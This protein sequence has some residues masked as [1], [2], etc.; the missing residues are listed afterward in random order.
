MPAATSQRA[1]PTVLLLLM[2]VVF[3]VYLLCYR[4]NIQSGDS[5]RALDALTSQARYG[6]WLLDESNWFKAPLI[7]R[8]AQALPLSEY[9]VEERLMLQL[10]RPL[11]LL[12]Q[13]LPRLGTIHSVW[14]FNII[15]CTLLTGLLYLMACEWGA[16]SGVAALVAVSA[17]LSS[18]FFA[19]S[20]TF[21]REPLA[22]FFVLLALYALQR[23]Q[24]G[25]A[26][27]R[28]ASIITATLVLFCAYHSKHSTLLALPALAVAALPARWF[29][30][31][32]C[33]FA[34]CVMGAS[35]AFLMLLDPFPSV[36][37][38]LLQRLGLPGGAT[39][40]IALRSYLL[41]PGTSLWATS[42]L[43][44]LALPGA[45]LW[46]RAGRW[47]ILLVLSLLG[48]SYSVGHAL[49]THVHWFGGLSWPP[50]FL[51]PALPALLL[52]AIPLAARCLQAGAKPLPALWCILLLYG[53]WIQFNS[54]ALSWE[55]YGSE[56]PAAAQGLGEWQPAQWQSRYFRWALLPSRWADLGFD[57]LWAR[58]K[59][60][61]WGLSFFALA[62]GAGISLLQVLRHSRSRLRFTAPVLALL[63]PVLL[64]G[65][66]MLAY[67]RDPRTQSHDRALQDA[68]A[69]LQQ[70]AT[71]DDVLLMAGNDN[72][73]FWLQHQ[74]SHQPR[75]IIL[76]RPF[77]QAASDKQPAQLVSQNP[78]DWFDVASFRSI[79]HLAAGH[80]RLWLLERTNAFMGWS[81]RPLERY[82]SLHYYPLRET[83]IGDG[84]APVRLL[85]FHTRQP[86][87]NPLSLYG[88]D[89]AAPFQFGESIALVSMTVP[90]GER[91]QP[92]DILAFSLLWQARA[93]PQHDATVASFLVP[94]GKGQASAQ[95]RDS[96]PQN[97]FSPTSAWSAGELT[98]DNR[99]MRIPDDAAPGSYR[100]WILLYY[101]DAG[102]IQRL[103]VSGREL[104]EAGTA[105]VLPPFF[106]VE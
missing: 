70:E 92:G 19:Y 45:V 35:L 2:L 106:L 3:G 52:A 83:A 94:E 8:A 67:N 65:N 15:V 80:E 81:F 40:N 21:F 36:L 85:E 14:L 18:N 43:L 60:P 25:T 59:L 88:G 62:A 53:M 69:T 90:G 87:P 86:A 44:L 12:A 55:V 27:W 99:A 79:H 101:R 41:S 93:A 50:R 6:D 58:A 78:N 75:G 17:A 26:G 95:G 30:R 57:F 103:P 33:C 96:A 10:A 84:D 48:F 105:A 9:D 72:G 32:A 24:R 39:L 23:G 100:L 5:L 46:W 66:L 102:D 31:R 77:A 98:W 54:A 104:A 97:G 1:S 28:V 51:L 7:I 49:L 38:S 47:Q 11:L 76:R 89:I 64:L 82:L 34:L 22:A 74:D 71:A 20:Q 29:T 73:A 42:P 61:L 37:Q 16:D 56:L 4:A 68:L 13:S 63:S 91:V